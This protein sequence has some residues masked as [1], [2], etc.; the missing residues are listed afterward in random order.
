MHFGIFIIYWRVTVALKSVGQISLDVSG[1][2]S[3]KVN[4]R[5]LIIDSCFCLL[6]GDDAVDVVFRVSNINCFERV[7]R[8]YEAPF[9]KFVTNVVSTYNTK[10]FHY[11]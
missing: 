2:V 5:K 1:I 6:G 10:H 4:V 8:F 7:Y 11:D 9:T 3:G